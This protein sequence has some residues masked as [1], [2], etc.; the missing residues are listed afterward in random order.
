M[1]ASFKSNDTNVSDILRAI[2]DGRN[3]LPDFQRGWVWDDHRIKALIASISNSYPVGALMF[4]EYGGDTIR[5]KCRPFT[6]TSTNVSPDMLVLDGQQRLTSIFTSMFCRDAVPTRTDKNQTINRY[7]YLNIIKCLDDDADREEDAILSIRDDKTVRSDFDRQIDL[8]LRTREN[9]FKNHM[10]PLNIVYDYGA[11]SDWRNDYQ[12]FYNHDKDILDRFTD[13]ERYVLRIIQDYKVPVITLD[14]KTPKEAVCQVFEN[15]NTGGV[16]LTVF[17]LITATYAAESETFE[18]RQDWETR[19]NEF[20]TKSALGGNDTDN[21]VLS[22]VSATDFLT[23]TTLY[24]RYR[25]KQAG[26]EAVSCKRKDVLKLPYK[27]YRKYADRISEGFLKAAMFLKEQRIFSSRDL[28]YS[29]QLIPLSTIF[30]LLGNKA[31]D[32]TVKGKIACWYWC[33]VLGEMY[34]GANETRYANDVTGVMAWIDDGGAEPETVTRAYFNPT[35]L[36]SLQTRLSA[37]YKGIMALILSAGAQDFISNSPMDFT[38]FLDENTDIHHIFPRAYCE[39]ARID[40][41]K[42]NA[43]VNKTPLF[44]RT[45]RIIGGKS[46]SDY[47]VQMVKNKNVLADQLD[48]NINSHQIKADFL[49]S[50][51]FDSFFIHRSK[52]LLELIGKAMGRPIGER[53]SDEVIKAFGASLN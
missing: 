38:V 40:K 29:T 20:I 31:Q 42:W 19:N 21:A 45:N 26:G 47:L 32:S 12:R 41:Q 44:A 39:S 48:T 23:A 49:Y 6:G 3:Q 2:G 8:D 30:A 27:D 22:G 36:L 7:Y 37:A 25:I 16:S 4:L 15:V 13:F 1:A 51:D 43:I 28:P 52:S 34:G 5:F 14:K 17:E 11:C 10:F 33:G 50:N 35:R 24:N 18:L 46:P 9:E 53:D